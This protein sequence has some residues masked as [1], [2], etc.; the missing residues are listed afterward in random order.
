MLSPVTPPEVICVSTYALVAASSFATG[1]ATCKFE[2]VTFEKS[3]VVEPSSVVVPTLNL[4]SVSSQ[5]KMALFCAVLLIINPA[6]VALDA[7]S[8]NVMMLSSTTKF[9]ESMV[10]VVP[11]TVRSPVIVWSPD[12]LML[13]FTSRAKL[14]GESVLTPIRPFVTST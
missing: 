11:C 8:F 1:S 5:M 13:P 2:S 12:T 14:P 9:C 7:F 3:V 6:S 4:S 10:V